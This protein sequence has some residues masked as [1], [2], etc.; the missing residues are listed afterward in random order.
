MTNEEMDEGDP[1][2]QLVDEIAAI[3][4]DESSDDGK[5]MLFPVMY[6]KAMI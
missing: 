6:H 3:Y 5:L 2:L 4:Y 1:L